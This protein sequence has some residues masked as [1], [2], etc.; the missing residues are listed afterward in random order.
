MSRPWLFGYTI[1][2]SSFS[3]ILLAVA[4][5]NDATWWQV[6]LAYIASVMVPYAFLAEE[7][8]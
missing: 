4:V 6:L 8:P 2:V 1:L 7:K 3:W 5:A